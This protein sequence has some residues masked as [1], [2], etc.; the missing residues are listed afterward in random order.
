[1]ASAHKDMEAGSNGNS[2]GG[3]LNKIESEEQ[4]RNAL[5]NTMS[6]SP[7]LFE[8]LYLS[9][10][11]RATGSQDLRKTFAN[12]TPLAIAGFAVGLFPLSIELSKLNHTRSMD[13]L[14]SQ[15][16]ICRTDCVP[17]WAG[18]ALVVRSQ[19]LQRL[20]AFSTEVCF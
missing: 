17:Q 13:Y 12:P 4:M 20:V 8:R 11:N 3:G 6:I 1:M 14:P 19:Q 5:T 7:E 15:I 9:P 2:N 16:E 18:G 10:E